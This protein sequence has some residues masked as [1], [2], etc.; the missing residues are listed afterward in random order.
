VSQ[1]SGFTVDE[2][3]PPAPLRH[4][5]DVQLTFWKPQLF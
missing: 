3:A 1:T 4:A 5:F 2:Q